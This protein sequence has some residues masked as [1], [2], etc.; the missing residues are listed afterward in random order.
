MKQEDERQAFKEIQH[1]QTL[2]CKAV[3]SQKRGAGWQI[4]FRELKLGHN[5]GVYKNQMCETCIHVVAF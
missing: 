3:S 1:A 4:L 5:P 2:T